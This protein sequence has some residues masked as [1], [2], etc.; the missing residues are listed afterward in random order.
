MTTLTI[1]TSSIELDNG[2]LKDLGVGNLLELDAPAGGL[3]AG[4]WRLGAYH[5]DFQDQATLIRVTAAEIHQL[6]RE[7][8]D[9]LK[10]AFRAAE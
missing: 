4:T 8:A 10:A 6:R 5:G 3:S 1:A 9:W 7:S 2:D